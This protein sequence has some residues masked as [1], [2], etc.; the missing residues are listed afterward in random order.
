[1]VYQMIADRDE[2]PY[3]NIT[4]GPQVPSRGRATDPRSGD[5][6]VLVSE[7]G[8]QLEVGAGRGHEPVQG[9]A[10]GDIAPQSAAPVPLA[11]PSGRPAISRAA[12]P[13]RRARGFAGAA[14]LVRVHW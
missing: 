13:A 7:V 3:Q 14:R 1:M 2:S 5:L 10:G 11:F 12:G 4:Q 8:D 9:I 6:K